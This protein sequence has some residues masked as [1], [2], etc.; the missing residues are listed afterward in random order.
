MSSLT[1][2]IPAFNEQANLALSLDNVRRAMDGLVTDYEIIVIDDGSIDRTSVIAWEK[3]QEDPRI[4]CVS[5]EHNQGYGYSYWRGVSLATKD[6][7]GVFTADNDM[8]W[9]SFR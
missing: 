7:V 8:S 9:E 1:V 6:Y 2:V 5:N 4:K 3:S